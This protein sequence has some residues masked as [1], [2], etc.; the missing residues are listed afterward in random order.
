MTIND[1]RKINFATETD[2]KILDEGGNTVE[3]FTVN[4]F[5][6]EFKPERYNRNIDNFV[7]YG[8]CEIFAVYSFC[9][10]LRVTAVYKK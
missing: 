9:D 7:K 5:D 10:V 2:Y 4:K 8:D 6:G 3:Y 1:F